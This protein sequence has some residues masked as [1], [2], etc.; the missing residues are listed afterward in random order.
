MATTPNHPQHVDETLVA[1]DAELEQLASGATWSEGPLW[2]P[3]ARVVRWSDIPGD[4]ILE[5]DAATGEQRVHRTGV[6]F[7]NG[8]ALLAD[9]AVVQCSHGRRAL[10]VE[11]AGAVETLVDHHGFAQLNSPNDVLVHDDGSIWFTDPPYGIVQPHEG[12][13][14]EQEYGGCAVFRLHEGVLAVMTLD[15]LR[16]NGI[17]CSPDGRTLYVTDTSAALDDGPEHCIWAFAIVG[18]GADVALR[19]RRVLAEIVPGVPDGIAVD[20]AG[21]IWSSAGDG[22]HVLAPDGTEL[23]RI[24]VPEVVGNVCF[25]GDDGDELFIAATT[26]L[27]RIRTTTRGLR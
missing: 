7:T 9:G 24:P 23:L 8:R 5:W 2:I 13:P 19:D 4:R 3:D 22:V 17:A 15:I 11:R 12:H 27:Y 14:G 26:S 21:R 6:E 20:V 18:D 1:I 16:P 25:G 10:E